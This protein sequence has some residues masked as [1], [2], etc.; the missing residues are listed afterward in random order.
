MRQ[1]VNRRTFV[2]TGLVAASTLATAQTWAKPVGP[3]DRIRMGFIGIGNRGTQLLRLFMEQPD[4]DVVAL[5]DIY[6]PFLQ[7]DNSRIDPAWLQRVGP[8]LPNMTEKFAKPPKRY[9]DYRKLLDDPEID[10]VC[11]ATP[12]HWHAI[13]SIDAMHAGKDVYCEKPLT[14]TIAE[15]RRMVQVQKETNRIAAVGLNRRGNPAYLKLAEILHKGGL[16]DIRA[17]AAIRVSNMFPD[18]IGKSAE[19]APPAG[20]DWN[21]WLG[22]RAFRPYKYTYAPYFF[23]WHNDFSSQ[24]GNWGVHYMDAIR[25]MMQEQAPCAISAHGSKMIDHDG[26]ISDNMNVTFEFASGRMIDFRILEACGGPEFPFGEIE[27]RGTKGVAYANEQGFR[28][29][30]SK[31]GQFQTWKKPIEDQ[32]FMVQEKGLSD[33]SSSVSTN[34]LIRDFVACVKSRKAPLCPLEEGHRSTSF[35]HLANIALKMKQRLEWDAAAERFTNCEA[36]NTLLHY[37]Y[38]EG[39]TLG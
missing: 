35:A 16:G 23:R 21:A 26:E 29:T 14:I 10:A 20:F 13:Q 22:P 4:V 7:R 33:G 15:G 5:C 11:I 6:D 34:G 28:I 12:D 31:P 38:R 18:G 32:E 39:Y 24:M 8:R 3:N 9:T 19:V 25:W 2:K 36:A 17:G 37:T 27:L 1:E 30:A